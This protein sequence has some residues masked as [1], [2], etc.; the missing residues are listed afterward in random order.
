MSPVGDTTAANTSLADMPNDALDVFGEDDELIAML[1]MLKPMD[2]DRVRQENA[3]ALGVQV[4]TLDATVKKA[5]SEESDS[6][7]MPFPEVESHLDPIDPALLLNEISITIMRFIVLN[8]EQA[9]AA[10]LWV[11]FTWFINVV[12]IAPLAIINAP[13]KACG[14]S[15]LLDL[16]GRMSARPLSAANSTSAFLFRAVEKW[17][18]TILIDEADTFIRQN[19][20]LKGLINA[21]YT[22][23]NAFV[24]R[25]VGEKNEPTLFKVWGAKA[26]AGI[27]LEKHLPDATMSRAI[28]LEL[29]RKLPS[30]KVSRLRDAEH[31]LF[32]GIASKLSRFSDD[33]SKQVRL[34][35]PT[36]PDELND[37]AQD[38]WQPLM[39]IAESAGPE[40]VK[41]ATAAALTLSS[42]GDKSVSTGN[43]LLAD[44]QHIFDKKNVEKIST[45][46]LIEALCVDTECGWAAYNRGKPLN[47]R[48]LARL[49]AT[50]G[51]QSKT[52]RI[53]KNNTPKGFDADQFKDAFA[54]YLSG[55]RSASYTRPAPEKL[56]QRRNDETKTMNGMASDVADK[57]QLAAHD[58]PQGK[59]APADPVADVA[60]QT[61]ICNISE[62]PEPLPDV[63]CGGVADETVISAGTASA[64][65]AI[66]KDRF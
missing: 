34:A 1:A 46:D 36:L 14:K 56:P 35:R 51:I 31:G 39:A 9:D 30:E 22:R 18:P 21:G 52:V 32:D 26:L 63:G 59:V 53:G 54:R 8:K 17:T 33:Y 3:K 23:A 65:H 37:R 42:A 29:R 48:Q 40:W 58:T 5:R 41:R 24:G 7:Y 25:V 6:A 57:T 12:E 50:Y 55:D 16:L 66:P 60:Q 62:T 61:P 28:V 2:Y 20:E 45:V 49:L 27:A 4:K 13:E 44:I 19:D 43:E 10:A 47:P 15:Q 64:L 38:N 11:A